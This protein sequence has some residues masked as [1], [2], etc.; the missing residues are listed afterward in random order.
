MMIV[1]S[2]LGWSVKGVPIVEAVSLTVE[3]NETLGLIGPNGSGK[4][5]LLR[6]L[7]GILTPTSGS[8][9]I[10]AQPFSGMSR[11]KIAQML[12][13]VEQYADTSERITVRDAVELGRTPWLSSLQ[14]WSR[15]DDV[16]V[17]QALSDVD[18]CHM[19]ARYWSTLSGGERQRVHLARAL[20]QKPRIM[21]LDEPTNHLDIQH[22]LA[23]P[24]HDLNQAMTCDRLGVMCKGR[25]VRV[26]PPSQVLTA[27]IL[28]D[29]FGVTASFLDDPSDGSRVIRFH[30]INRK[31]I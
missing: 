24:L 13:F 23:I 7:A 17:A 29:I 20:A 25:L 6:L 28:R 15:T 14:P 12:G 10:D 9:A 19:A 11:R 31:E 18:M 5:T 2:D 27:E 22:Q 4:S 16:I 1:A 30:S 26:G 21:L 3:R 8:I